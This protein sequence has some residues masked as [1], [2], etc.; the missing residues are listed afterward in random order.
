MV[1]FDEV[2]QGSGPDAMQEQTISFFYN[3]KKII[4]EDN[5]VNPLFIMVTATYTKPLGKYGSSNETLGHS[6]IVLIDW[7][8]NM[9]MAM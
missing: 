6:D 9:M 7:N 3:Y 5:Y 8:Y 1:F 2:H 4:T